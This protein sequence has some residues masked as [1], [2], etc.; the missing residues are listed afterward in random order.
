MNIRESKLKDYNNW[1]GKCPVEIRSEVVKLGGWAK[2]FPK[3]ETF[4]LWASRVRNFFNIRPVNLTQLDDAEREKVRTQQSLTSGDLTSQAGI[5]KG[6]FSL[7]GDVYKDQ[8]GR[9]WF[10]MSTAGTIYHF[11]GKVNARKKVSYFVRRQKTTPVFK[12]ISPDGT[13]GSL[14]LC[15][16]N[17]QYW[18]STKRSEIGAVGEKV[19]L[20]G[21]VVINEHFQGSYNYSDNGIMGPGAHEHRDIIPHLKKN[22]FYMPVAFDIKARKF[23]R[24]DIKGRS[25]KDSDKYFGRQTSLWPAW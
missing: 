25:I 10:E 2:I 14:E 16:H 23:P 20:H 24:L 22:G 21:R 13:G 4:P 7:S 1:I 8:A 11:P 9:P 19:D 17:W 3:N 18:G 6:P 15:I 12:L 5:V